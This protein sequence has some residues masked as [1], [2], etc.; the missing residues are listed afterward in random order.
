MDPR[1]ALV[2]G[3]MTGHM[4]VTVAI[5]RL[6]YIGNFTP[7]GQ[8]EVTAEVE[9][10]TEGWKVT[11]QNVSIRYS[12]PSPRLLTHIG[13]FVDGKWLLDEMTKP[14]IVDSSDTIIAT[15]HH[16]LPETR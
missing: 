4:L 16:I 14:T 2:A 8:K 9:A 1:T 5:G 13:M 6:D 11:A 7:F 3:K 12:H 15:V 10:V